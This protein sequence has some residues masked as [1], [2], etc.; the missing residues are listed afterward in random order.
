MRIIYKIARLELV[1]LFYSPVAWLLLIFLVFIIGSAFTDFFEVIAR[2]KELG[3]G[4]G[5]ALSERLFYA[6]GGLWYTVKTMLYFIMPLLTMGLISQEYNWG[7]IKFLFSAPISSRQ[8]ILGKYLGVMLYGLLVVMVLMFYMFIAWYYIDA[9]EW[10]AVLSGLLGL[11]LLFGL[12]AAIGL[13]MSTLTTYQIV[14]AIGM[15]AVLGL[16][17]LTAEVGQE[18]AFVRDITYWLAMGQRTNN[19]ISGLISS[20]DVL[21][22]CIVGTMFLIF[23]ILRMQLKRERCTFVHKTLRYLVVFVVAM[24][25]GYTTSLPKMK[26]YYDATFNKIN[27]LTPASQEIVAKLDGDLKIT[28]YVNLLQPSSFRITPKGIKR[29]MARYDRFVRFKPETQLDYVFYY[30]TDTMGSI[31]KRYFKEKSLQ[32]ALEDEAKLADTKLSRYTPL[33]KIQVPVDLADEGYRFLSV[34]ERGDGQR[35]ILRSFNDMSKLASE[36]EISAALK[37]LAMRLLRVGFVSDHQARSVSTDKNRDYSHM[38]IQKTNRFALINQGFDVLEI[39]LE[40]D[41]MEVDSLDILIV[42]EP[43]EA[44]TETEMEILSRYVASGRN[45]IIAG[46]PKTSDKLKSL[47][48][49][50][51]VAFEQGTLVQKPAFEQPMNLLLCKALPDTY[52]FSRYFGILV[53]N[54]GNITMP[55]A[56]AINVIENKGF[57]TTPLLVSLDPACWNEKQTVDF[58]NETPTL[59]VKTGEKVGRRVTMLAMERKCNN[60]EQRIL[61]IGDADCF[62]AGELS[63]FRRR[64]PTYNGMLINAMFD[65]LSYSELPV[66]TRHASK[67]DNN[68][69]VTMKAASWMAAMLKWIFPSL[70]LILCVFV[71]IRR[72]GK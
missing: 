59:D 30:H 1:N 38:M 10:P 72:K 4:G 39:R 23:S 19:F 22:F 58:V 46:K 41:S 49:L 27:T 7:T 26:F 16:L 24:L 65:W 25:L 69:T 54:N 68:T 8:I 20:E 11:Y 28:T 40:R 52:T 31:Y 55:G 14:A 18:Y 21:Y 42:A 35:T 37:R 64:I 57:K 43:L 9:F 60:R 32:K 17:E 70:I 61:V 53:R 33:D 5:Y 6:R 67:V 63:T 2:S 13:F 3:G 62:S 34:I 12:Y 51:G 45:L 15:F 44:F 36:T 48:D 47:M 50:L 56:A 29:D 71:L 66:N